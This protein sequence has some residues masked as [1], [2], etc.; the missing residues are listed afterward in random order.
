MN[1]GLDN[2]CNE[3]KFWPRRQLR[4]LDYSTSND[5]CACQSSLA[6][7]KGCGDR[8]EADAIVLEWY[9][10]N[11]KKKH[12]KK[13]ENVFVIPDAPCDQFSQRPWL[14][15]L[16]KALI[17][18]VSIKRNWSYWHSFP[19]Q[20]SRRDQHALRLESLESSR[21]RSL[22]CSQ[23]STASLCSSWRPR[24]ST[25]KNRDSWSKRTFAHLPLDS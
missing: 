4:G 19:C 10:P 23:L 18:F 6:S 15:P 3:N 11:A 2:G 12:T 1:P 24:R 25:K 8:G 17:R 22:R 21:G 16:C 14:K 20:A 13:R 9:H 5:S 7:N